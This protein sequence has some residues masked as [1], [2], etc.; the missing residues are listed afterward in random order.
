[1]NWVADNNEVLWSS[2]EVAFTSAWKDTAKTQSMYSQLMKLVMKDLDINT[3]TTTFECLATAAGWEADAQG[4]IERFTQGLRDNVHRCCINRENEPVTMDEW[5]NA[6]RAETQKIRKLA[7]VGLDFCSKQR[8]CETGLFQAVQAPCPAPIRPTNGIVPMDMNAATAQP[9]LQFKKLTDDE[10]AQHMA[11]GRC[12]RCR[13]QG[14]MA[15][16]CPMKITRPPA[17]CTTA[18]P[19]TAHVIDATNEDNEPEDAK[20]TA[21]VCAVVPDLPKL[22]IAQ[23][24]ATLEEQMSD[25]ECAEYLDS[26]DMAQDFYSAKL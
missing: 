19:P 18:P 16:E 26:C 8:S 5:K 12:F 6:A 23:Q 15:H 7:N 10:W 4:I 3:Y 17:P 21:V 11:E 14:H 1:M 20:M 22:T 2:F 25:E 9:Q 24:I 13:Q